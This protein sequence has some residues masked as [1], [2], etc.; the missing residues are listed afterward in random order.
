MAFWKSAFVAIAMVCSTI[1]LPTAAHAN[2]YQDLWWNPSESGWGINI[3]QQGD[4]MFATW[5]IYGASRQPT[6]IFLSRAERSGA[7]GNV[8][9]R[10]AP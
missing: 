8:G 2:N 1:G 5:F 10:L 7:Q 6:W 9:W 3:A 4:V